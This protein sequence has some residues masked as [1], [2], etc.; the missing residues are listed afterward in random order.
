MIVILVIL[1]VLTFLCTLLK[2]KILTTVCFVILVIWALYTCIALTAVLMVRYID[3][4]IKNCK[5][6][7]GLF[8]KELNDVQTARILLR[9]D[10]DCEEYDVLIAM[11]KLTESDLADNL[12]HEVK[13]VRRLERS[14]RFFELLAKNW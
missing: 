12:V 11:A 14:K 13:R 9:D 3:H 10:E 8:Y 4:K 2:V 7:I 1:F 6:D 5:Q